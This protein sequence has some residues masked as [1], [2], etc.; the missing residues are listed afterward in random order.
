MRFELKEPMTVFAKVK[1]P[2][3]AVR[4]L[5]AV[6]DFNIPFCIMFSRDLVKLGYPEAALR[7][8]DWQR[9][10]PMQVPY[11]LSFRGIE[12][13]ILVKASEISVGNLTAK[14]VETIVI[15]LDLPRLVPVDL[16]LGRSFL[17]NFT[18]TVDGP[19][20]FLSL[21]KPRRSATTRT[22]H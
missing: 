6:L 7:P 13:S 12:R 19:A 8:K 18:L 5:R 20:G 22:A 14:E 9:A 21:V 11:V 4:E 3:G 17:N 1:G 10:H 2:K 15:D 16:Y